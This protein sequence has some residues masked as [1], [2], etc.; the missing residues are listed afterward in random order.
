M[1][2]FCFGSED[3]QITPFIHTYHLLQE[4]NK[5]YKAALK[6]FLKEGHSYPTA[7]SLAFQ[8]ISPLKMS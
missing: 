4:H 1:I 5:E 8:T 2:H 3:G 6:Q 7:A